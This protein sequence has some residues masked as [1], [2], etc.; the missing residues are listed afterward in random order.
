MELGQ[1]CRD[2][3]FC[4]IGKVGVSIKETRWGVMAD[5]VDRDKSDEQKDRC[6][7]FAVR[8]DQADPVSEQGTYTTIDWE[9]LALPCDNCDVM[10][11][12]LYHCQYLHFI[13]LPPPVDLSYLKG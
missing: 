10:I 7:G 1:L 4:G 9:G 3:S 6:F 5:W 2:P 11:V 8:P 13:P 12:N